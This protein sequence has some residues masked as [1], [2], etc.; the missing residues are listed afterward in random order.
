M[1]DKPNGTENASGNKREHYS[2]PGV[3]S[4]PPRRKPRTRRTFWKEQLALLQNDPGQWYKYPNANASTA[5]NMRK[6]DYRVEHVHDVD[7]DNT[8]KEH[9]EG[10]PTLWLRVNPDA[11]KPPEDG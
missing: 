5:S 8:T 3:K 11:V 1:A 9:P 6:E 10:V 2:T 4:D 7:P